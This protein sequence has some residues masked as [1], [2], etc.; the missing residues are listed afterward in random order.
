M[1]SLKRT[2]VKEYLKKGEVYNLINSFPL[3][4]VVLSELENR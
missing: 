1:V 2:I 3:T 4:I